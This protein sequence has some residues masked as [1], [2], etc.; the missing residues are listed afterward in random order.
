MSAGC[1]VSVVRLQVVVVLLRVLGESPLGIPIGPLLLVE[2]PLGRVVVL[3]VHE[4]RDRA[5]CGRARGSGPPSRPRGTRRARGPEKMKNVSIIQSAITQL[6]LLGLR[7]RRARTRAPA[8]RARR[9][10]RRRARRARRLIAGPA[11]RRDG[12]L[13]RGRELVAASLR[14]GPGAV[15]HVLVDRLD[16]RGCLVERERRIGLSLSDEWSLGARPG[17]TRIASCMKGSVTCFLSKHALS[18]SFCSDFTQA[19]S[20]ADGC[21]TM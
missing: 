4:Q 9:P 6:R 20:S 11:R 21:Q 15:E 1:I 3:F 17:K 16:A 5:A 19:S 7:L 14:V 13:R 2:R 10:R 18:V 12:L 8:R